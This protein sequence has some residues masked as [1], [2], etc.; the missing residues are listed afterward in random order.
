LGLD[1]NL[2]SA[3]DALNSFLIRNESM[4][5]TQEN[6]AANFRIWGDD[7]ICYG[8]VEL[9]V[10]V[11]WVRKGRVSRDT[12][13][14]SEDKGEW[15]R[16]KEMTDL[17]ILFKPEA[18]PSEPARPRNLDITA[19]ALHRI[20][21]LADLD[22]RQLSSFLQYVKVLEF[23]PHA[24]IFRKGDRG[25]AMFLVLQGEVRARNPVEGRESTLATLGVGECFGE[26]AVIDEG[27]RSADVITNVQSLLL[28]ISADDFKRLFQE[29]P[30]LA[31]PFLLGLS[32]RI[33][34]NVRKL[35]KRYEDSILFARIAGSR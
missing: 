26:L 9:P 5:P 10:L 34:S 6:P 18:P 11:E 2:S 1:R 25:D 13:V 15:S 32:K 27:P 17:K 28:T 3:G 7:S 20:R 14:F 4:K 23:P 31:A 12:W 16:A 24:T 29:A 22:Q 33:S 30:S 8:P 21:I 19:E 35:T